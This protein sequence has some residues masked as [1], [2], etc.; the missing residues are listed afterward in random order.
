EEPE[1]TPIPG[2]SLT[3]FLQP[4]VGAAA[5]DTKALLSALDLAAAEV[6]NAALALAGDNDEIAKVDSAVVDLLKASAAQ[7]RE[8]DSESF[9][10]FDFSKLVS[11]PS[12]EGANLAPDPNDGYDPIN[13]KVS[14][15]SKNWGGKN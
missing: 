12:K 4:A 14:L 1:Y 15:D 8:L 6:S 7:K 5:L 3:G 9:Q 11:T 13:D 2:E 10:T